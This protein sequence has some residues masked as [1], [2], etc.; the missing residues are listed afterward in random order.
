MSQPNVSRRSSKRVGRWPGGGKLPKLEVN[1]SKV[2][3][4]GA[5]GLLVVTLKVVE[6]T[7]EGGDDLTVVGRNLFAVVKIFEVVGLVLIVV[8]VM[9]LEFEATKVEIGGAGDGVA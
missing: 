7:V 2:M 8:G 5:S 9:T 3:V 4:E 6:V 1:C